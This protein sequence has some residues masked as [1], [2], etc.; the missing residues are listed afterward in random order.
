MPGGRGQGFGVS[1]TCDSGNKVIFE[2]DGVK[3]VSSGARIYF[4]RENNVNVLPTWDEEAS[5]E[6]RTERRLRI[7]LVRAA[8]V[9]Q[10]ETSGVWDICAEGVFWGCVRSWCSECVVGQKIGLIILVTMTRS[11]PLREFTVDDCL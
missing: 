8:L 11:W 4:S 6:W 5:E 7:S 1:R 9:L 3:Y 2:A 10:C